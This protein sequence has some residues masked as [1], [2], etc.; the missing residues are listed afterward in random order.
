MI[1]EPVVAGAV[2]SSAAWRRVVV[3]KFGF[4][5]PPARPRT[6]DTAESP[7]DLGRSSYIVPQISESTMTHG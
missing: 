7:S 3:R 5:S 4:E 6:R 2:A 1:P